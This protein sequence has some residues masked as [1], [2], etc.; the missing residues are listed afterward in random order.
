MNIKLVILAI[1]LTSALLWAGVVYAQHS[2][3]DDDSGPSCNPNA[4]TQ[5]KICCPN[6]DDFKKEGSYCYKSVCRDFNTACSNPP[7]GV[8]QTVHVDGCGTCSY[9][10]DRFFCPQ[11]AA[12]RCGTGTARASELVSAAGMVS[13]SNF[14]TSAGVCVIDPKAAFV[15]FKLPTYQDLKSIHFTQAKSKTGITKHVLLSGDKTEADIPLTT[16]SDHLYHISGNLTISAN[17]SGNQTGII[18]VDGNLIIGPLTGNQL[19]YGTSYSG[20]VLVVGGDVLIDVSI[21]RIDAVIISQGTICTA[22]E[23]SPP[24]CPAGPTTAASVPQLEVN[25]SLI[26]L[27]AQKPIRFRRVLSDNSQPAELITAQPKYLAILRDL[28]SEPLQKWSEIP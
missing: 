13:S 21:E 20:L 19:T 22:S 9:A 4:L 25:G 28:F 26:N 23:G 24:A 8:C 16:G 10:G 5:M 18:F 7:A 11:E 17:I 6:N 14:G 12:T 2:G 27:D 15:S 3:D 1:L